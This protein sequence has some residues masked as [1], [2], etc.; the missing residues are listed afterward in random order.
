MREAF[1]KA[2][3][4]AE[5][6]ALAAKVKLG[7]LAGLRGGGSGS[8]SLYRNYGPYSSLSYQTRNYLQQL[9]QGEEGENETNE[10]EV[11]G[12]TPGAITYQMAVV[13]TFKLEE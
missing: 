5:E 2:K 8:R 12:Y 7:P 1:V 3:K 6:L 13:A 9:M 10:N 11:V 4:S